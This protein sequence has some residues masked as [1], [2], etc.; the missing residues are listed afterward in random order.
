MT[1]SC[2]PG[3]LRQICQLACV[4]VFEGVGAVRDELVAPSAHRLAAGKHI[5]KAQAPDQRMVTVLDR[6][7]PSWVCM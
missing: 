2:L 3:L 6:T 7:D 1:P 4:D 5:G